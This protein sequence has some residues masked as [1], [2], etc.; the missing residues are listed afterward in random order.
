MFVKIIASSKGGT[1][2]ETQSIFGWA[3]ITLDIGPHCS[4]VYL[5][6]S[7]SCTASSALCNQNAKYVVIQLICQHNAL[8]ILSFINSVFLVCLSRIFYRQHCE[9][10]NGPVFHLL[11]GRF[12]PIGWNLACR[13]GPCKISPQ[14]VQS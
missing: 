2:Y 14:S 6:T 1:F 7:A 9:K 12:A 5:D 10:R 11:R 13:R 8:G 4:L 3:A